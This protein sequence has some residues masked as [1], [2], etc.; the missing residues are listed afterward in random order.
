MKRI[1]LLFCLLPVR[2]AGFAQHGHGH[3]HADETPGV[4]FGELAEAI[5][6]QPG[7]RVL[8]RF[9]GVTPRFGL[10][11]QKGL[12]AEAGLGLDFYRIG[13][14]GASEFVSFGYDNIRPYVSG[15]IMMN[16]EPLWGGKAGI[17][18]IRSTPI[19][20]MAFGGEVSCYTD[21]GAGAVLVTPRLML[22][23][24]RVE[25]YYGYSLFVR[26]ELTRWLGHHRFGVSMTLNP[27]FWRRKARIYE[28]YY[29]TY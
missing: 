7:E 6:G 12:F 26:N 22:S 15:E 23:F 13:Y 19:L 4:L 9:T 21:G 2:F 11:V 8:H 5:A 14:T 28:D 24:V 16:R 18:Y 25:L 10:A 27:R 29:D 3:D 20:G 1:I 17:E